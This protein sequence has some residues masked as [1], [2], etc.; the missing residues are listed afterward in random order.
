MDDLQQTLSAVMND[1][2]M[3]EKIMSLA[4]SLGIPAAP[5]PPAPPPPVSGLPSLDPATVQKL[6][7]L[8]GKSNLDQ[9]QRAL[10]QALRPYLQPNR[11]RRLENAMRGAKMAGLATT[12]LGR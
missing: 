3:M 10:L 2:G 9:N 11:L 12:L 5:E 1:P 7:A 4:Q 6:T 8:A